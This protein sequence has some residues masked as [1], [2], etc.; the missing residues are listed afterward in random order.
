MLLIP[1]GCDAQADLRAHPLGE[2]RRVAHCPA[3]RV[4]CKIASHI[5]HTCVA[6]RRKFKA[7][8]GGSLLAPPEESSASYLL[9]SGILA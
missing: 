8:A 6:R 4:V 2:R 3:P 5:S 1:E 9:V 7:E